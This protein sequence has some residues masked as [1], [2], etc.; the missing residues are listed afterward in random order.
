[1][2]YFDD[3]TAQSHSS[4]YW[5]VAGW[6][7]ELTTGF[8]SCL[9]E[10][11]GSSGS[12]SHIMYGSKKTLTTR[13]RNWPLP[14]CEVRQCIMFPCT[15]KESLKWDSWLSL[16]WVSITLT[17][18]MLRKMARS[19]EIIIDVSMMND[20]VVSHGGLKLS[21]FPSTS[22]HMMCPYMNADYQRA[23]LFV[24]IGSLVVPRTAVPCLSHQQWMFSKHSYLH[25]S[26]W[27]LKNHSA[28]WPSPLFLEG[29]WG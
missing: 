2:H 26:F 24:S 16:L 17:M 5:R 10:N 4:K 7:M 27:L 14:L 28:A 18:V 8:P 23:S 29:G 9:S 15:L 6:V 11:T 21:G 25:E 22:Y 1:M 19:S 12:Q 20:W 3:P 13:T